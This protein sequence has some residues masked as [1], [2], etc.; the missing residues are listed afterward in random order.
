MNR[1]FWGIR[2]P[3]EL[4]KCNFEM[5]HVGRDYI[6]CLNKVIFPFES[7]KLKADQILIS[8]AI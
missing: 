4:P 8:A 3:S 2:S 7:A 1:D 6:R 5:K